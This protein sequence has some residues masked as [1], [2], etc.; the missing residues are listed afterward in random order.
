M[1]FISN[2]RATLPLHKSKLS[3]VWELVPI[4]GK[5]LMYLTL[6]LFQ[7]QFCT[8][9]RVYRNASGWLKLFRSSV[10]GKNQE[11]QFEPVLRQQC[12]WPEILL[13]TTTFSATGPYLVF[14]GCII[15]NKMLAKGWKAWVTEASFNQWETWVGGRGGK[16]TS[17]RISFS[18]NELLIRCEWVLGTFSWENTGILSKLPPPSNNKF[19]HSQTTPQFDQCL[20]ENVFSLHVIP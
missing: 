19:W 10:S 5:L 13:P 1:H 3:L 4:A 16:T 8:G 15:L 7:R 17:P 14:R 9:Y 20:K 18:K 12:S 6:N 2:C 11:N